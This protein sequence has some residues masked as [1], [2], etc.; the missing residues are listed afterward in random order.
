MHEVM[1]YVLGDVAIPVPDVIY[2]DP[3]SKVIQGYS[4]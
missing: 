2:L 4:A 3:D 1:K